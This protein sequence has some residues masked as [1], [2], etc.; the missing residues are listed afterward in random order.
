MPV[1]DNAV[2]VFNNDPVFYGPDGEIMTE[3]ESTFLSDYDNF[4][5][6]EK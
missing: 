6:I 1:S 2:H 4:D 5:E 3:E